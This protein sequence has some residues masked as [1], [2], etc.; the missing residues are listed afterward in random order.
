[1]K[2]LFVIIP[3]FAFFSI[4]NTAPAQLTVMATVLSKTDSL[5]VASSISIGQTKEIKFQYDITKQG[6]YTMGTV[7][8]DLKDSSSSSGEID[9]IFS[10]NLSGNFLLLPS[11]PLLTQGTVGTITKE[12]SGKQLGLAHIRSNTTRTHIITVGTMFPPQK[13]IIGFG[14]ES[15]SEGKKTTTI[16][17]TFNV[18]NSSGL[19]LKRY[20]TPG[21][22]SL[23]AY[24]Y[25]EWLL[26]RKQGTGY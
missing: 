26:G 2:K 19:G 20:L 10:E 1:M 15:L 9:Y 11:A 17:F 18:T 12:G 4:S 16:S 25:N 21:K 5:G 23:P 24:Y 22:S 14:Q 6:S 3:L 7:S 8:F 13:G